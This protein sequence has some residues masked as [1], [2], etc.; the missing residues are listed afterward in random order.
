MGILE[1]NH[2][3]KTAKHSIMIESLY[4]IPTNKMMIKFFYLDKIIHKGFNLQKYM[5]PN[6]H[7]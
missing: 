7:S 6:S 5:G 1:I 2:L 3:M 4:V